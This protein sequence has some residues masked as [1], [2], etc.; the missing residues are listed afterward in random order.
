MRKWRF[1]ADRGGTFTDIIGVDPNGGIHTLKVLSDSGTG[2]PAIQGIKEILGI[3][4]EDSLPQDRVECIRVGTTVVTNALLERK[5]GSVLLVTTKGFRDLLQIGYQEREHLFQICIKR[6]SPLYR[7]VVEVEERMGPDGRV[8]IPLEAGMVEEAVR[9]VGPEEFDAVAVVF[10]HSWINPE[11]ELLAGEVLRGLGFREVYLSH[12]VSNRIRV[13]TRGHATVLEAYLS[14]VLQR[15]RDMLSREVGGIRVEFFCSSG[16]TKALN[17]F[18]ARDAILSGPAGGAVALEDVAEKT[19]SKRLVG[20][21]MGGTSTDVCRYDGTLEMLDDTRIAGI[22]VQTEMISIHTIA[23]GG[24]SILRFQDGRMLVGPDSAG[25]VPGPACYGLGGP[26]TIT[27]ANLMTG[28]LLPGFMPRTFGRDRHSPVVLEPVREGFKRLSEIIRKETDKVLTEEEVAMG[29]LEVAN[30]KMALAVRETTVAKGMDVREY[31]LVSYGG[32]AGQHACKVAELLEIQRVIFHPLSSMLSAYGIGIAM[33]EKRL[34]RSLFVKYTEQ[35][36]RSLNRAFSELE[37]SEGVAYDLT[38]RYIDLRIKGS[39]RPITV[40]YSTYKES[41]REFAERHKVLY[42]FYRPEAEIEVVTIRSV[43]KQ[44]ETLFEGIYCRPEAV[45]HPKPICHQRMFTTRGPQIVPVYQRKD[46]PVGHL[47]RGA[48]IVVEPYTTLVIEDGF[49]AEV[50]EDGSIV[51]TRKVMKSS[52]RKEIDVPDPVLL[53]VFNNHFSS[54]ATEMGHTLRSTAHSVNIRERQDYSCA[55]F[56]PD[57]SLV[58]NAPHIPVH[59]GSM[60]ETVRELIK[61]RRGDIRPGDLYLTNNPYRGG[62]HLPDLTVIQPVFSDRGDLLFFTAARGHHA[63]IGGTTPGSIPPEAGDISEEGVLIDNFL[64]MRDGQFHEEELRQALTEAPYPVRNIEQNM[65]DIIAQIAACRKGERLLWR[66]IQRYGVETVQRYMYFIQQN[67]EIAVREALWRLLDGERVFQSAQKEHLDDGTPLAVTVKITAGD[68]PPGTTSV[69]FDFSGTGPQHLRDNLNAPLSVVKSV[70]LYLLRC[71]I[72]REI[73]LNSGCLNPVKLS[74][75][76]G[77][78]LNPQPP[79]PVASGNVETS[80]RLADLL[81]MALG[82]AAA[83][84]GTM[85]NLLFQVDGE[86]PYYETIGGGGGGSEGC[87]G[88]SAVQVHMT[89]TRITDPEFLE[90]RHPGVRLRRFLVRRG[91][92]GRGR[93]RGGD[94][95]IREVEFL[96][97]ATVSIVSERRAV[98]PKGIKGGENGLRGVNLLRTRNGIRRLQHR[99][100]LRV[101]PGESIIIKT[102]GG[103]G[104]GTHT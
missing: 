87:D 33:P 27:D 90:L 2:E 59:I 86:P 31:T 56:A 24:G 55:I 79:A 62:S 5:G 22:E 97:R 96:N 49:D 78:I 21:D 46:L 92:G 29:F 74:V 28:R 53:E 93:Y 47:L 18:T 17:E 89:N 82:V 88:G 43:F 44:Q 41:L 99:V 14:P 85:N 91:S 36:H 20:L 98:P 25:A 100:T 40:R 95:I 38:E 6:P 63:D 15:Y 64:L 7:K 75:P 10:L 61:E 57:G 52:P 104:F 66:L 77:S 37:S 67:A 94:G 76:E 9:Q 69:E 103:G 8:V 80:Q 68:D 84:Q 30:E 23:S 11:H 34:S 51:A 45:D 3:D 50:K 32:A 73:P 81:F 70:L 4:P 71:L 60:A 39:E 58:A 42:G 1:A 48:C 16:G 12:A 83:S 54:V 26:L 35:T 65:A 101:A 13:V 72:A 102:P 19:G